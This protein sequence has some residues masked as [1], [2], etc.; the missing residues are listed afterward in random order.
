MPV[1][2]P[3]TGQR[4]AVAAPGPPPLPSV[5]RPA[6]QGFRVEQRGSYHGEVQVPQILF[7]GKAGAPDRSTSAARQM[8]N[9]L[10]KYKLRPGALE[11]L[12]CEASD[13]E[14]GD[15]DGMTGAEGSN[16]LPPYGGR[17]EMMSLQRQIVETESAALES[18]LQ[19]QSVMKRTQDTCDMVESKVSFVKNANVQ[20][21]AD[22]VQIE[23]QIEDLKRISRAQ[24]DEIKALREANKKKEMNLHDE[25]AELER[26]EGKVRET[27]AAAVLEKE[28]EH[29]RERRKKAADGEATTLVQGSAGQTQL[30]TAAAV[31]GADYLGSVTHQAE[32]R[33][34]TALWREMR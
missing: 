1:A 29:E 18:R 5:V 27:M 31:M 16:E 24:M 8:R 19:A 3:G 10:S 26:M 14:D 13:E 21:D 23:S 9:D 25:Q 34:L 15:D 11:E 2:R 4:G 17:R 7:I 12:G 22:L 20:L 6:A 32:P 33:T 28:R 30:Q